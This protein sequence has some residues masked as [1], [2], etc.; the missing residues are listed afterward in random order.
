MNGHMQTSHAQGPQTRVLDIYKPAETHTSPDDTS[1]NPPE[2]LNGK[3][4]ESPDP[5]NP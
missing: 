3:V 2:L 4:N 5:E 1:T